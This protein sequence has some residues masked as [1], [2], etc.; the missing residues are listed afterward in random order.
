LNLALIK[1]EES[2][3]SEDEN[4]GLVISDTTEFVKKISNA[5]IQSQQRTEPTTN[6]IKKEP[7]EDLSDVII[8]KEESIDGDVHMGEDQSIDVKMEDS[9]QV[10]KK[11]E[12]IYILRNILIVNKFKFKYFIGRS[13]NN[14]RALGV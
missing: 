5:P 6:L 3:E 1:A 14:R 11:E 9:D 12:V 8:K 13:T 10:V 2:S 7:L 4:I